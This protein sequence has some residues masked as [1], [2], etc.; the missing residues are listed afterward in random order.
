[1]SNTNLIEKFNAAIDALIH[2]PEKVSDCF[3]QDVLWI[4]YVPEYLPYGG[5]YRGLDE[6]GK[7]FAQYMEALDIGTADNVLIATGIERDS[8]VKSTGKPYSMP[9]VWVIRF[10]E[11][12][13]INYVR[14]YN[15]TYPMAEAFKA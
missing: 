9:F 7:L 3:T 2:A 5:E 15:D 1:M 11:H 13:K 10:N 6:L 14:E 12:G 8:R 4:N